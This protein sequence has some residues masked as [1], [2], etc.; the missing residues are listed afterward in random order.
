MELLTYKYI[1]FMKKYLLCF[2]IAVLPL[3]LV[4]CDKKKNNLDK[5][6]EATEQEIN[7]NVETES[8]DEESPD[9]EN[10][11]GA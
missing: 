8:D 9:L 7:N 4:A 5:S 3:M 2:L 11:T 10:A 1:M 6:E